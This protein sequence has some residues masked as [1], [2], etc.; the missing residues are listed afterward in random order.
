MTSFKDDVKGFLGITPRTVEDPNAK[1]NAMYAASSAQKS[2]QPNPNERL[3]T[4]V[5]DL[6]LQAMV[7]KV[8]EQDIIIRRL[9]DLV[10]MNIEHKSYSKFL[11]PQIHSIKNIL[12]KR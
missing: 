12:D 8:A 7:R 3:Q 2:A 10:I 5:L 1:N 9:L 4:E 6:K 11:L